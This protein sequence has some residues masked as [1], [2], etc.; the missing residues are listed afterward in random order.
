MST[1]ADLK[2]SVPMTIAFII[3]MF[4]AFAYFYYHPTTDAWLDNL[5]KFRTI[6]GTATL[7][8]SLINISLIH[9]NMYR[10]KRRGWIFSL[11]ILVVMY[12]TV[13]MG[14]GAKE[15]TP[16]WGG[17]G[18]L[19]YGTQGIMSFLIEAVFTPVNATVFSL[20][21]FFIAS[22]AYRSFRFRNIDAA[23]LLIAGITVMLGQAPIGSFIFGPKILDLKTWIL[24]VPNMA[25]RRGTTIGIAVGSIAM[26]VRVLLGYERKP[27]LGGVE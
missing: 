24:S 9:G 19:S 16:V 25:G 7:A 5:I 13:V 20:L 15:K 2:K 18:L 6:I 1:L 12:F 14:F 8:V 11:I 27:V 26:S 10:K 21:A 22:A 4:G 23:I 17:Y 3:G